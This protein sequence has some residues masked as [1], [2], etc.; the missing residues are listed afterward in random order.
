MTGKVGNFDE[1]TAGSKAVYSFLQKQ[2]TQMSTFD[3]NPLWKVVDGPWTLQTFNS[4]GFY[5]WVPNKNYSGPDKP[6]LD[7]VIWTPFTTDTAEM[8]TLRSGTS[9]DLGSLPLNDVGQIPRA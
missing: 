3:S 8:N 7:K 4:N 2:G 1:T 5:A 9:L 6:K